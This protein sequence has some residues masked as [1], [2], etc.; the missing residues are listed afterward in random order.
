MV[1]EDGSGAAALVKSP[2]SLFMSH[3]GYED[4]RIKKLF[5]FHR[6]ADSNSLSPTLPLLP[7]HLRRHFVGT[8]AVKTGV[9]AMGAAGTDGVTGLFQVTLGEAKVAGKGLAFPGD[10]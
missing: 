10:E 2:L 5:S 8:G 1:S 9:S 6:V 7:P 4:G 3:D